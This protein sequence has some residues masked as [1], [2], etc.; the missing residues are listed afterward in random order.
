MWRKLLL[1][2]ISLGYG[3]PRRQTPKVNPG[4]SAS[5]LRC[6][7]CSYNFFIFL[8]GGASPAAWVK[9]LISIQPASW[10]EE[11]L[12]Q[13]RLT[14]LET[15][16]THAEFK[17]EFLGGH[18]AISLLFCFVFFLPLVC[19]DWGTKVL[20]THEVSAFRKLL[21]WQFN[22]I[23]RPLNRIVSLYLDSLDL[24]SHDLGMW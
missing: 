8:H 5:Q 16:P 21:T 1:L 2:A 13:Q 7:G 4:T 11:R 19:F 17:A 20:V 12:S 10:K 22:Y 24:L 23:W 18:F 15:C 3:R 9:I 6:L 14:W